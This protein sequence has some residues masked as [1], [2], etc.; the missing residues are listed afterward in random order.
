MEATE[1]VVR[2]PRL[3]QGDDCLF[4]RSLCVSKLSRGDE[5][6]CQRQ[7][8]E[9]VARAALS[10][11]C[12]LKRPNRLAITPAVQQ[13]KSLCVTSRREHGGHA[14]TLAQKSQLHEW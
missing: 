4:K 9:F 13:T 2:L 3:G 5:T 7:A 11:E 8:I 1:T 10:I 14:G 12:T 6:I